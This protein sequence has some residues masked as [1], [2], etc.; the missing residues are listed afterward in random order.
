MYQSNY[1]GGLRVIDI[2]DRL[3]PREVGSFDTLPWG[4]NVA[5]F[6]GSWT[7][8]P[9]FNSGNIVVTSIREGLF[10]LRRADEPLP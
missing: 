9:Y 5:G 2:S 7:N 6:A 4:E 1:L 10:V 3:N 8:Y